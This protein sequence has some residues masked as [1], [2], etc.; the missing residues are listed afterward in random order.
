[1]GTEKLGAQ[2]ALS[3]YV[4]Q[5]LFHPVMA[6]IPNLFSDLVVLLFVSF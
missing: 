1:M 6:P 5:V 4:F 3:T 2:S